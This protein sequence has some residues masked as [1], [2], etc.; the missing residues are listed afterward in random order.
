MRVI[1]RRDMVWIGN[2]DLDHKNS[3]IR[4]FLYMIMN[5]LSR[6]F[7]YLLKRLGIQH[8][9]NFIWFLPPCKIF[10]NVKAMLPG[11]T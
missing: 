9:M 3:V 4:R 6:N 5:L 1:G 10:C 7:C 2:R 11:Q 8:F